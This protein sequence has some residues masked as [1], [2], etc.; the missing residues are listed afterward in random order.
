MSREDFLGGPKR[1][2]G[3]GEVDPSQKD[4]ELSKMTD[5]QLE[6]LFLNLIEDAKS[7]YEDIDEEDGEIPNSFKETAVRMTMRRA[8]YV[9]EEYLLKGDTKINPLLEL[10][11]TKCEEE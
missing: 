7:Q 6:K 2:T 10:K 8:E 3:W 5:E 9:L 1:D 11:M 4:E